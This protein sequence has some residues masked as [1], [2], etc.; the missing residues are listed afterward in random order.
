MADH[1][2]IVEGDYEGNT[3]LSCTDCGHL[4]DWSWRQRGTAE[5]A[6]VDNIQTVWERHLLAPAAAGGTQ[7]G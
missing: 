5:G 6:T 7:H 2:S 4:A 1:V 3:L